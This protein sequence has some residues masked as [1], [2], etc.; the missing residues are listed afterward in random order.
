MRKKHRTTI[1]LA[2]TTPAALQRL[3]KEL[4]FYLPK[5]MQ[6]RGAP[7]DGN[8]SLFLDALA[9]AGQQD[10]EG[11]VAVLRPLLKPRGDNT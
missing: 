2:E 6:R 10:F 7:P 9:D 5:N 4:G 11:L 1:H 3:A 8:V